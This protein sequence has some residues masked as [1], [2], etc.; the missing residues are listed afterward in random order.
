MPIKPMNPAKSSSPIAPT[1]PGRQIAPLGPQQQAPPQQV[2]AIP[3]DGF[4]AIGIRVHLDGE[5]Q[6]AMFDPQ[7]MGT[8]D[9]VFQIVR[10]LLAAVRNIPG[11]VSWDTIPE[12]VKRHLRIQSDAP[13]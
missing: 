6:I 3:W 4:V 2:P 12:G 8:A 7:P 5:V 11:S 13:A 10:L 9:E 1:H